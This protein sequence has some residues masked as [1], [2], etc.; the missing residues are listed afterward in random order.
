LAGVIGGMIDAPHGAV[1]A[2]LLAP[3]VEANVRVLRTREPDSPALVRYTDVA[4]LLTGRDDV[5][6]EDAAAWL[7]ETVAALDVQRLG[8]VGLQA[9]QYPEVAEKAMRSSS[10]QGN[11]ARL[12]QEELV[13]VL[14]AAS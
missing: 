1:C 2:A 7:R 6:V 5:S 4:R 9:A 3:V 10:M 13:A 12:S 14:E 8:A 11:P